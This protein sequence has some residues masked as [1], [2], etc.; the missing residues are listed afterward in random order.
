MGAGKSHKQNEP[1][2]QYLYCKKSHKAGSDMILA[3]LTKSSVTCD[4]VLQV[5][6]A[7]AAGAATDPLSEGF[8]PCITAALAGLP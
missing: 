2:L 6:A 3:A 4:T 1:T 8:Q 5:W 7:Q